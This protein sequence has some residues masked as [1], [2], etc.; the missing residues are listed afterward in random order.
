MSKGP[1]RIER[2]ISR[3]FDAT[4]DAALTTEE[5]AERI[6]GID[7]FEVEVEKKHRVAVLR[8]R[9]TLAK[10]R[11]EIGL[12]RTEGLGGTCVFYRRD[13]VASYALACMK[14][15]RFHHYRTHDL[16]MHEWEELFPN[17]IVFHEA[18]LLAELA[19][20]IN[21]KRMAP[22]GSWW[23]RTEQ[24]IAE[25]AGDMA[26]ATALREEEETLGASASR[27]VS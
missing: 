1:G 8:A 15:S 14:S 11:P 21:Q 13:R 3:I 23:L 6:Y 20:A 27:D 9:R 19:N 25:Q 5:L 12:L 17:S 10:T 16:R 24:F 26:R 22:G 4:P 18:E 7:P 2:A